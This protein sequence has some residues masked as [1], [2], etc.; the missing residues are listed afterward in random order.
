MLAETTPE[1]RRRQRPRFPIRVPMS[2]TSANESFAG[3]TVNVSM[4]GM[5]GLVE[6]QLVEFERV[7]LTFA[8]PVTM[9]D[10]GKREDPEVEVDAVVV[11]AEPA[12]ERMAV[13][14]MFSQL[15]IEAE[16][17][18]GKHLLETFDGLCRRSLHES[19]ADALAS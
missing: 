18:I 5:Y 19:E 1:P 17:V 11:R 10:T 16:W 2:V 4:N 8:L 15:P 13:A 3:F 7:T 9:P 12:G 14:F 6:A